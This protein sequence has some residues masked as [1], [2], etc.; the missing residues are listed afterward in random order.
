MAD[1]SMTQNP[2]HYEVL[3]LPRS[4]QSDTHL[5]TQTLRAAYKRALLQNH[6]DKRS[7]ALNTSKPLYTV[8]QISTAFTILSDGKTKREYDSQL[9]F[10]SKSNKDVGDGEE[11]FKTGVEVLDLEDLEEDEKEN[12]WYSGCRC[13]DLRGFL[14]AEADLE[15]AA[16]EGEISVGCRGCSLWIKV[17][18]GL[19]DGETGEAKK[20]EVAED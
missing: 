2:T 18:F 14:V 12:L 17:L 8:D 20:D 16:E 19:V 11:V 15:E 10:S 7:P 9:K 1:G 13:G 4:L 6:P 5:P 3:G